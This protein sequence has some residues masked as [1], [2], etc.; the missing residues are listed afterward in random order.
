MLPLVRIWVGDEAERATCL[1]R[2]ARQA[3]EDGDP[4]GADR[5]RGEFDQVYQGIYKVLDDQA[6][7][8][9]QKPKR[10]ARR[11][12]NTGAKNHRESG[13]RFEELK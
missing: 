10:R 13:E 3:A 2:A 5:L 6:C 1:A 7:N 11:I 4:E 8:A 12:P 9:K